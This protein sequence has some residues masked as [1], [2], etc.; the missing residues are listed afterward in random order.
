MFLGTWA[1]GSA[2]RHLGRPVLVSELLTFHS[3]DAPLT[4]PNVDLPI[5]NLWVRIGEMIIN[6]IK[7][8]LNILICL[9]E[10]AAINC[11]FDNFSDVL[12]N[13]LML[14]PTKFQSIASYSVHF[15]CFWVRI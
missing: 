9:K 15:I 14:S 3:S 8:F 10:S 5:S 13:T 6:N 4:H 1:L 12:V 7:D 2:L 11:P